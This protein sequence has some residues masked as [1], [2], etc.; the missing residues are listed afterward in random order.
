M[1]QDGAARGAWQIQ[2]TIGAD[3]VSDERMT[4]DPDAQPATDD[5]RRRFRE[6]LFGD[7]EEQ[8]TAVSSGWQTTPHERTLDFMDLAAAQVQDLL[9]YVTG[10]REIEPPTV[11]V[12][13]VESFAI[14]VRLI[15]DFLF[16]SRQSRD[17]R[18]RDFLPKWKL[19]ASLAARLTESYNLA[20]RHVAH[21]SKERVPDDVADVEPVTPEQYRQMAVAC[22]AGYA[23]FKAAR[24]QAPR[25]ALG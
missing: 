6:L 14:N 19:D 1:T 18:A 11:R 21:L 13:C 12:A 10:E 25:G 5:Q 17:V 2:F 20:S 9:P 15:G 24:K 22:T 23:A 16:K 3:G 7:T 8:P 4:W